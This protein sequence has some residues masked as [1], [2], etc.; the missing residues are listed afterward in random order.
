MTICFV[1]VAARGWTEELCRKCCYGILRVTIRIIAHI[2]S[3][4]RVTH[5]DDISVQ[6]LR[7]S[8]RPPFAPEQSVHPRVR[9]LT[10]H[11]A[12]FAQRP[13]TYEA[14]FLQ[15]SRR[16]R[17][18]SIGLGFDHVQVKSVKFSLP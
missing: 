15:N 8:S 16:C 14:E 18:A 11:D 5:L 13:F 1:R 17:V 12:V 3:L 6:A 9:D 10:T 2:W 4:Y 7:V